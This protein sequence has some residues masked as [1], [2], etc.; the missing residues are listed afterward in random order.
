M[1][2]ALPKAENIDDVTNLWVTS[3]MYSGQYVCQHN[4]SHNYEVI[5]GHNAVE[6]LL[7]SKIK[8]YG[9]NTLITLLTSF[10]AKS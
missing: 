6:T 10:K 8:D 4:M 2:K 7:E 9:T 5:W 3:P 1:P